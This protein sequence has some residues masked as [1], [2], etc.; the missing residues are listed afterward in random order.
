[1]LKDLIVKGEVC[2]ANFHKRGRNGEWMVKEWRV[3]GY[4][5]ETAGE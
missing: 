5:R 4:S 2:L 1:L 3:D